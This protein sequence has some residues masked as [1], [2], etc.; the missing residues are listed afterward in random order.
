MRRESFS[1]II[2][3]EGVSPPAKMADGDAAPIRG[4]ALL[5][6]DVGE[7]DAFFNKTEHATNGVDSRRLRDL[8]RQK[9]EGNL[10][11][12]G[13]TAAEA[14]SALEDFLRA[15][16]VA[17]R[18]RL[19]IVHGRGEHSAERRAVLRAKTRKWLAGCGAVLAF[20]EPRG[21]PGAVR[22]LLRRVAR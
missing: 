17:G 9:P 18:R 6:P 5:P 22:V 21:N 13:M 2:A 1:E 20:A 14:H 7:D 16:I 3:R 11:L 19:E 15:Q 4:G 10:D 8:L 12:H